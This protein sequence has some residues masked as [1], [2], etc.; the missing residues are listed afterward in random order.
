MKALNI[1]K[2]I[3]VG[4]SCCCAALLSAQVLADDI[5]LF[6]SAVSGTAAAPNVI[7][8]LDN[9][10]NWSRASQHW[11]DNGG[12]QG[13]AEA[14]AIVSAINT[15]SAAGMPMNIG[16]AMFSDYA[17]DTS[18]GATPGTGGGY[19]RF[20]A[21]DITQSANATALDNILSYVAN[22]V[23][24]PSEKLSGMNQKDEDAGFYELYKYLAARKAY[25][26]I[27][28]QN[29]E[30]DV[31][32]NTKPATGA[33]QGLTSGFAI[34][35]DN[36]YHSPISSTNCGRT[37]IIYISNN[38][39]NT[40]STG[41]SSYQSSI[42]DVAP[43]LPP[44]Y[45]TNQLNAWTDEWTHFLYSHGVPVPGATNVTRPVVTYVLDAYHDQ[46]NLQY[47]Y[48]LQ[49]AA[50]VGGGK[51]FHVGSESDIT[52]ALLNILAEIQGVNS[53]FA[54][55]ALPVNTTN[56]SQNRN[57]VF[58]PMFRPDS[59]DAP[60]WMGNLKEYQLI[61]SNGLVELGDTTGNP[62][63][64]TL[65]GYPQDC[66]TS[67]W[68]TDSGSYWSTYF[69][70]P[71]PK[72]NCYN[73]SNDPF[74]DAPDGSAVEK[75]GVA[76]VIRKG[77]NPPATN[78]TPTW[79]VNRKIYTVS[80][81]TLTDFTTTSSG[82][83]QNLV[84]YIDGM[85]VNN[86]NNNYDSLGN[87]ITTDTRPTLHGDSIHSRPMPIDYGGTT[88]VITYYGSNDG[89]FRAIDANDGHE[90]WAFVA[91]E[92]FSKLQRLYDNSPLIYYPGMPAGITPTPTPKDYFFDGSFGVYQNADNSKVWIY[93]SMRR[94]GRVLYAFDV[95]N[96]TSPAF[97]WKV[98]CPNLADN[99][100]CSTGMSGIGQT[101]S[102]PVV[103]KIKGYS[104]TSPV[105]IVGGGYDSCEDADTAGPS[106]G[107]ATGAEVYVL[108]ADTGSL[109]KTFTTQRSVV[110]DISVLDM[111]HDGAVDVGYAVDTG[112]NIYRIDFTSGPSGNY[113]AQGSALWSMNRVAYTNGA[114]RKFL[115]APALLPT[116]SGK[117]YLALGSGD[118]EHPLITSY[119]Y[120]TPVLNRF[121]VYL[122]DLTST[123]A[124][125]LDDTNSFED[126]SGTSSCSTSGVLP[127]STSKGWFMDLNQYGTGEQVVTSAIIAG[128]M[129][130]FST[131]RPIP[132]TAGSCAN[133]LGQARGY[134]VN[135]INGSGAVGVEGSC[136]GALSTLFTGGGLPPSPVIGV[137]SINGAPT[138]VMLG[139][140]QR[141]GSASGPVSPQRVKPTIKSR[142][143][144]IYW[145]FSGSQ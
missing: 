65:T 43:A 120:T 74:S 55:A 87:P 6:T 135:L 19:I 142:R 126:F 140:A 112:G 101:W 94:G 22:N 100:G 8:L 83:S 79:S 139:A 106:C 110:A 44:I 62:A 129:V 95:T 4:L 124:N 77:N 54:S 138:T 99:T 102:T 59:G 3:L 1:R 130:T 132:A 53:T 33:G 123:T 24:S 88:G 51:Y 69:E 45:G 143:K 37:Y 117:V 67:F 64:N 39:N 97:K 48:L 107:S 89:M 50:K 47:S 18:N 2:L 11:P 105:V 136:G 103:A 108:D 122:D 25:S 40:G 84:D 86:E 46:Q 73:T 57:Q 12:V 58:I 5:D 85:D 13:A 80:G 144:M 116:G 52:K 42:A 82:L 56:R 76:E 16:L 7:I 21:R 15:L 17:G 72:S 23:T 127:G 145:K 134:W 29:P 81:T 68:T 70:I 14:N 61:K 115:F 9:S 71:V 90:L 30:V 91:P 36:D 121:Y 27:V 137:V 78:T 114:G 131:N 63:I 60:R 128:G 92:H 32:G 125:N 141:D 96:P 104:T 119:P 66:A 35:T 109:I 41:L 38:A 31:S 49:A 75:G 34:A 28:S 10:P 133:S 98:G 111:D 20:G 26:G 118:R 113:A 93:P